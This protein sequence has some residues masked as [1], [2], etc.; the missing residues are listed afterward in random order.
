MNSSDGEGFSAHADD[1]LTVL[2]YRF[3][4]DVHCR[5]TGFAAYRAALGPRFDAHVL[6][7]SAA[8][9]N[10][11]PF[12]RDVARVPHSLLTAHLINQAG[13]PT[14]QARDEFIAFLRMRLHGQ[15][16]FSPESIL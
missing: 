15:P 13:E 2:A 5:A 16:T 4:G 12:F 3:E 11:P 14:L 6:P 7:D 10:P 8:N 1:D 9:R